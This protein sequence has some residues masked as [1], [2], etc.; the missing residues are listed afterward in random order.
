MASFFLVL[1]SLLLVQAINPDLA[2]RL[3]TEGMNFLEQGRLKEAVEKFRRAVETDPNNISA[4]KQIQTT[5]Q[6]TTTLA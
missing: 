6:L 2:S 5:F 4:S 1:T 3:N